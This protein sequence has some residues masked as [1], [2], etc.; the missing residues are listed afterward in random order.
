MFIE[1]EDIKTYVAIA[2][3]IISVFALLNGRKSRKIAEESLAVSK[4]IKREAEI[5]Y[6][7]TIP[8]IDV[9]EVI[10]VNDAYRAVLLL[11][12]MRS[13]PFRIN[14]VGLN[15]KVYKKRNIKNYIRSKTDSDFNWD[16]EKIDDFDWNPQGDLD[17]LEKYTNEAA[18]FL[19]VK[20]Q[21]KVLITIPD[22][23]QYATY[24]IKVN[25][26]HGVVTLAGRISPDGKV[27]F[28]K[29]FKQSFT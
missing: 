26:T 14:C 2:A 19:V 7:Q 27:Y 15:K 9:L 28:C 12:N 10:K 22:F 29:E 4:Q 3:F 16:Y 20:D 11:S 25:T 24:Q 1:F 5:E 23:N 18:K 21:E 8:A 17:T 13:T 6:L